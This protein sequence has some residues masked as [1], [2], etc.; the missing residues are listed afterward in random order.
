MALY[1]CTTEQTSLVQTSFGTNKTCRRQECVNPSCAGA[2]VAPNQAVIKL[3][4]SLNLNSE[5]D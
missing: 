1:E 5:S 3:R 2:E 4:K